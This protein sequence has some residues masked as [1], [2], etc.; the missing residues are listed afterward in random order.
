MMKFNDLTAEQPGLWLERPLPAGAGQAPNEAE[1]VETAEPSLCERSR[2][3]LGS[4]ATALIV[5][6]KSAL[7]RNLSN[8]KP[9]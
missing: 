3:A 7:L 1:T 6:D 8:I 2:H 4:I 9:F 5:V